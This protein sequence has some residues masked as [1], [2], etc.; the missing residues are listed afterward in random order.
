MQ[1]SGHHHFI[2]EERS[3]GNYGTLYRLDQNKRA[4]QRWLLPKKQAELIF[5]KTHVLTTCYQ[6]VFL[7]EYV[8]IRVVYCFKGSTNV[9]N[10]SGKLRVLSEIG[11]DVT[12]LKLVFRKCNCWSKRLFATQPKTIRPKSHSAVTLQYKHLTT[13]ANNPSASFLIFL[14][15][16]SIVHLPKH[17]GFYTQVLKLTSHA[18]SL[19]IIVFMVFPTKPTFH[20]LVFMKKKRF[21]FFVSDRDALKLLR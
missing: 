6:I 15:G 19:P 21:I 3:P 12:C 4:Y 20:R 17:G 18:V 10:M 5:T 11:T 14:A 8:I 13:C 1:M 7:T 9:L 16:H 2:P